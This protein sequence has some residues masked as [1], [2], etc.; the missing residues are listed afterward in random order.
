M[1]KKGTVIY[2]QKAKT[3]QVEIE[4]CDIIKDDFWVDK[5]W[6]LSD[7]KRGRNVEKN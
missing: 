7:L 5:P 4:F 6:L 1:H 3:S 2:R